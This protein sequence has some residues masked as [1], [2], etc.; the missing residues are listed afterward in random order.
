MPKE[1]GHWIIAQETAKL[2]SALPIV[3]AIGRFQSWFVLGSVC[4]DCGFYQRGQ[5]YE[6]LKKMSD[7]LH[8]KGSNDSFAPVKALLKYYRSGGQVPAYVLA[9]AAGALCHI[10]ADTVFHPM[11]FYYTGKTEEDGGFYR[12]AAFESALDQYLQKKYPAP[13]RGKVH[14]AYA[15]AKK[16]VSEEA[17]LECLGV[18]YSG[19]DSLTKQEARRLITS[20]QKIQRLFSSRLLR[21]LGRLVYV[22]VRGSN[23]D[24]SSVFYPVGR[25]QSRFFENPLSWCNPV[26]GEAYS[27]SVES[28]LSQAIGRGKAWIEDLDF[29]VHAEKA[30]KAEKQEEQ[31]NQVDLQDFAYPFTKNQNGPCLDMGIVLRGGQP[32]FFR[33]PLLRL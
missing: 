12:H 26:T 14:R 5:E 2:L 13:F 22:P 3:M 16:L 11:I 25:R 21:L 7:R 27:G 9:F 8:G 24:M 23:K 32:R 6:Y 4:H 19:D 29:Y 1:I 28:L 18:F 31:E 10:A 30:E 20:H 33:S 17:F 15:D